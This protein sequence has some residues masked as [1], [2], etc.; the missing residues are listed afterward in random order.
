MDRNAINSSTTAQER[1]K[2]DDPLIEKLYEY[3]SKKSESAYQDQLL[4]SN[5]VFGKS[6]LSISILNKYL[7]GKE[8]ISI[9]FLFC[10]KKYETYELIID[11]KVFNIFLTNF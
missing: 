3:L 2:F 5:E 8:S 1:I 7:E 9:P 4:L 10:L 6:Y 11:D